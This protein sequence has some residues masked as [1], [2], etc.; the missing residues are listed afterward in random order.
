MACGVPASVAA[1]TVA[2]N[3]TIA[4]YTCIS[5]YSM[6]GGNQIVCSGTTWT[7]TAPTCTY[8]QQA[9]D[10]DTNVNVYSSDMPDWLLGVLAAVA[11]VAALLILTCIICCCMYMCGCVSGPLG[12]GANAVHP[13]HA[14]ESSC[15]CC[16]Q[17]RRRRR[18]RG[19]DFYDSR[20]S[21]VVDMRNGNRN[22]QVRI[23]GFNYAKP[24][25]GYPKTTQVAEVNS[26]PDSGMDSSRTTESPALVNGQVTT[27]QEL[28]LREKRT[29]PAK[30]VKKWMPHSHNV[31]SI[32]TSTK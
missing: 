8:L 11:C 23:A 10:I 14:H 19:D 2:Y 26:T 17:R 12:S 25:K 13:M 7:G 16:N 4:T 5:G 29:Q 24:K 20:S 28:M 9:D 18:R 21:S 6:S 30:E 32:N 15:C 31:R 27:I 22:D 1:A 3:D